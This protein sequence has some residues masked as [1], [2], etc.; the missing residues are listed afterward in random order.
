MSRADLFVKNHIDVMDSQLTLAFSKAIKLNK[1]NE[2]VE[3][4]ENK[5]K[6]RETPITVHKTNDANT[7]SHEKAPM[8]SNRDRNKSSILIPQIRSHINQHVPLLPNGSDL[9]RRNKSIVLTHTCGF[10]SIASIYST[11]YIDH[12]IMRSK[13]DN[14]T[15]KFAAFVKLLF[16]YK[17]INSKI[18]FARYEFL[19]HHFPDRQ[20]IKELKDLV[21]F[22]CDT[23]IAGLY[24]TMCL[25]NADI[26]ASR[27][28][29]EKCSKCG[30][31]QLSESPFVNYSIEEF[32]FKNVQQ[33]IVEERNRVCATCKDKSIV[34][35]DEFHDIVVIDCESLTEQNEKTSI[36]D[37]ENMIY[38][39]G[40][41]YELFATIQYDQQLKH[42]IPHIK[43]MTN[44]W[45]THDDLCR[46]K[47][48]TNV[49]EGMYI[50]M[51]FYKKKSNGMYLVALRHV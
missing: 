40:V 21:A 2:N 17:E 34:I 1:N 24:S 25:K 50:F 27:Q 10:D 48:N 11:I 4:I 19:R 29:T 46:T 12:L 23:A 3:N 9:Q 22:N 51:L 39:K 36:N 15:S 8:L 44:N 26:L 37:I 20:A 7:L 18:E 30:H 45:E 47:S 14:S 42:F 33:S 16:Q 41:E 6:Y 13:I 49:D 32:E 38:L 5:K 35:E 43:R 28:R 31:K